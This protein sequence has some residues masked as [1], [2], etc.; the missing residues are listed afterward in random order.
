M[1]SDKRTLHKVAQIISEVSIPP[2]L[3]AIVF[4]ILYFRF[5]PEITRAIVGTL[6]C[7]ISSAVFPIMYIVILEK[8]SRV[9]HRH[10]PI[11][12]QR[13]RPYLVGTAGYSVGLVILLLLK[14]PFIVWG[15]MVCYIINTLVIVVINLYWKVSAHA[16]GIAGPLAAAHFALGAI[17][18]PF[19]LL[20]IPV[21]WARLELSAHTPA[22]LLA[23]S[24][25]G[26]VLTFGQLFLLKVIC[27]S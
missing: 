17:V 22:Q 2:I 24:I 27:I 25:L 11:K 16:M 10:I 12:E 19:Y 23:G 26:V 13:T 5:E 1:E 3:A 14:A 20:L 8:N 6:V 4:P 18:I 21:S 9:S 7:W 15:L